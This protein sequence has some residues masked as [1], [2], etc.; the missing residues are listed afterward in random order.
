VPSGPAGGDLTGNYPNP[1]VA[2]DAIDSAEVINEGLTGADL[3]SG[4]VAASEVADNSLSGADIQ[5]S[6]LG[7]VPS[8]LTAR[9]GGVGRHSPAGTCDP[10]TPAFVT[11][12]SVGLS[13]PGP[14]RVLVLG[15]VRPVEE[16]DVTIG[17][18]H[19]RLGTSVTGG[20]AGSTASMFAG[21]DGG[22]GK[23]HPAGGSGDTSTLSAVSPV[24]GPGLVS[25][26]IDC[27]QFVDPG[28]GA[29]RYFEPQVTAVALSPG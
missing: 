25:F 4:S 11:C 8:A 18:G 21:H 1:L 22:Y 26:G 20:I 16:A 7:Q 28:D 15:R 27:N 3:G 24:V 17:F 9:L 19:C 6:A 5:E 14:A 23:L 2:A 10:E 29:L 12:A 13:L